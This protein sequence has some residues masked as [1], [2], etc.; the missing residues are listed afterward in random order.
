MPELMLEGLRPE[1]LGRIGPFLEDALRDRGREIH[2]A[3]VVGSALTADYVDGR[4]DVN[5][6]ILLRDMDL[7]YLEYLAPL[8]KKYGKRHVAAPHVLTRDYVMQSADV[9]PIEYLEIKL[10][11]RTVYGE[12]VFAPIEIPRA[13]LRLQCEREARVR[14]IGLGQAYVRLMGHPADLER[15][16]VEAVSDAMHLMRAL[17]RL[18]RDTDPPVLKREALGAFCE[19]TGADCEA[20]HELLLHRPSRWSSMSRDEV[21]ARFMKLYAAM[22]SA[23]KIANDIQ[24]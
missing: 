24:I 18:V 3:Y 4:S 22:D 7:G 14:L 1:V 15:Y 10:V 11:H 23:G 19:I 2:S 12:D 21:N 13:A 5:T 8:G 9:F 6:V 17:V 20:L 16:L